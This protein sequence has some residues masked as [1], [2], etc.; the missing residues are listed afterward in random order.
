MEKKRAR[1]LVLFG[2]VVVL[3]PSAMV[4]ASD[5]FTDVPASNVF[6]DDIA[7]LE[8]SGV[9][10]GC[11]PPANDRFCPKD[12]VTREQ[13][14]AFMSRLAQGEV[15][16]ANT[17]RTALRAEFADDAALLEGEPRSTLLGRGLGLGDRFTDPVANANAVTVSSSTTGIVEQNRFVTAQFDVTW[18]QEIGGPTTTDHWFVCWISPIEVVGPWDP[19]PLDDAPQRWM[20]YPA[21][22]ED[23]SGWH[24]ISMSVT[25][26]EFVPSGSGTSLYFQC[27]DRRAA[28]APAS[29]RFYFSANSTVEVMP[30]DA[31]F[32]LQDESDLPAGVFE[33][34]GP[35]RVID[36]G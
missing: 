20:T 13:M 23:V 35:E 6:H 8:Q 11:N 32:Y 16:E 19:D 34:P 30:V 17:A 18:T 4:L 36:G 21:G 1:Y 2:L 24:D 10:R 14:A 5:R 31:N 27:A 25:Y 12:S 28:L 33:G 7:W 22:S 29:E 15:V 9:T 26:G 3:V